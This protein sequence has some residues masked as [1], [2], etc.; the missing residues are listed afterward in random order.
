MSMLTFRYNR[1]REEREGREGGKEEASE[2]ELFQREGKQD[3]E[4]GGERGTGM[5][6]SSFASLTTVSAC[7][8]PPL[9]KTETPFILSSP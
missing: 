7:S 5:A 1:L 4:G 3:G 6:S 9:S 8:S 2:E